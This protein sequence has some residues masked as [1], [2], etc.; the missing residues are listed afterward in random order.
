MRCATEDLT[1]EPLM[2]AKIAALLAL[3]ARL[4]FHQ[5]S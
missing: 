1:G 2:E 3:M 4:T 5:A